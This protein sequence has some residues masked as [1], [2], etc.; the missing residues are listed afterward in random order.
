MAGQIIA[1][2]G[3]IQSQSRPDRRLRVSERDQE[4]R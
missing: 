4:A 1:G 3:R 2:R